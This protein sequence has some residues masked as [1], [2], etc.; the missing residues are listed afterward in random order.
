VRNAEAIDSAVPGI[1]TIGNG[2]AAVRIGVDL[3][4]EAAVYQLTRNHRAWES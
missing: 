2:H 1:C 3:R 4:L